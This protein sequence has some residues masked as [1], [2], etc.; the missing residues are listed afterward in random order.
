MERNQL[1]LKKEFSK[2]R[3]QYANQPNLDFEPYYK[4]LR[5]SIHQL[6]NLQLTFIECLLNQD[7]TFYWEFTFKGTPTMDVFKAFTWLDDEDIM[8]QLKWKD[9]EHEIF[10]LYFTI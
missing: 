2:I 1:V 3:E 4:A 10:M 5:D 6:G 7:G 9:R 8:L